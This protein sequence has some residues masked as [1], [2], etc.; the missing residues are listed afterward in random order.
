MMIPTVRASFFPFLFVLLQRPAF[1]AM[2]TKGLL[3]RSNQ[4]LAREIRFV[5]A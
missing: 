3:R 5:F 1:V 4:W 2:R